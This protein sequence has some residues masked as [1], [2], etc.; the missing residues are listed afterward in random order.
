MIHVLSKVEIL[1][2]PW[3]L[4]EEVIKRLRE[5]R[6]LACIYYVRAEDIPFSKTI[7]NAPVREAPA[8]FRSSGRVSSAGQCLVYTAEVAAELSFLIITGTEET[9]TVDVSSC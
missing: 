4:L 8:A 1:E 7:R 6:T 9:Y 2:L 3:Q 5:V